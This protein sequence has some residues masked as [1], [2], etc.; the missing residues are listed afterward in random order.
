MAITEEAESELAEHLSFE[1]EGW[2]VVTLLC[3]G[4]VVIWE[5]RANINWEMRFL[6][7]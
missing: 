6:G 2:E 1:M 4:V 7:K 3:E 5:A